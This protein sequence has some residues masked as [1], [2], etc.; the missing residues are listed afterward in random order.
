MFISQLILGK[1][2]FGPSKPT[3]YHFKI[4]TKL[5]SHII[6][7]KSRG[8]KLT[9]RITTSFLLQ[10]TANSN[11][12]QNKDQQW[13]NS[14]S[15]I[16]LARWLTSTK[17]SNIQIS[18]RALLHSN[19]RHTRAPSH[20]ALHSRSLTSSATFALLNTQRRSRAPRISALHVRSLHIQHMLS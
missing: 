1:P 12:Q 17:M 20:P 10:N 3:F 19:K 4:L 11:A 6:K 18:T 16:I 13:S 9:A 5:L 8:L 14:T 15:I 2:K 7:L